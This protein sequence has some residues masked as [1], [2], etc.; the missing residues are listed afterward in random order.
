MSMK[1]LEFNSEKEAKTVK[2]NPVLVA[3]EPDLTKCRSVKLN[4]NYVDLDTAQF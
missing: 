1:E 4:G 2:L 3:M